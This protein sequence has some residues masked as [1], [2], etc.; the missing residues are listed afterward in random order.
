[1]SAILADIQPMDEVIMPSF[2]FVST[3]NAFVLRGTR[4]RVD[5]RPDTLNIDENLF[6]AAVNENTRAIVMNFTPV[7]SPGATPVKSAMPFHI[8]ENLKGHGGAGG[9]NH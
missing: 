3:T 5:I 7:P 8:C 6:E 9:V 1:M 4:I 2:T